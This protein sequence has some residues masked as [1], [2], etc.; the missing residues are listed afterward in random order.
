MLEYS[1]SLFAHDDEVV[2]WVPLGWGD[3]LPKELPGAARVLLETADGR[4]K[5]R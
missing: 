2:S 1:P 5:P 4:I 3:V